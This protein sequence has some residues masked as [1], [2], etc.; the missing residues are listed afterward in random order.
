MNKQFENRNSMFGAVD[1]FFIERAPKIENSSALK[2]KVLSFRQIRADIDSTLKAIIK[3]TGGKTAAKEQ[4][5]TDML[6]AGFDIK[7]ALLTLAQDTSNHELQ[8][9]ASIPEWKLSQMRDTEQKVYCTTLYELAL[10][11]QEPIAEYDVTP[12]EIAAFKT[13]I[14]LFSTTMGVREA[15]PAAASALRKTLLKLFGDGSVLLEKIDQLMKRFRTKDPEFY[16]GYKSA[17]TVKAVGIRHNTE[18]QAQ[19]GPAGQ[20]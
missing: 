7:S 5:E 20:Q 3:S 16:N 9:M 13:R 6:N 4:A 17:R 12:E 19:P 8:D 2:K 10:A 11:N 18:P 15:T 1:Q 14:D